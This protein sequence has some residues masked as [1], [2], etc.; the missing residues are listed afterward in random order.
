MGPVD[1]HWGANMGRLQRI[2]GAAL[3][4]Y[5]LVIACREAPPPA[6][7]S[8]A[9]PPPGLTRSE[10][11][12]LAAAEVALPPAGLN[13]ADLPAPESPG[14]KLVLQYCGQCHAVPSPSAHSATDWPGVVRRMW[15]RMEWLPDSFDIRTPPMG[16][17]FAMLQY[18]TANALKVSGA[19]LPPGP[20]RE[21]FT[22]TCSRCHDLPDPRVHSPQDWPT[23]V[24][25]MERNVERMKVPVDLG[26]RAS[27]ILLY[28]QQASLR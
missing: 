6:Q 5:G 8:S 14:A 27:D 3:L 13:P 23:V 25:R 11:L 17:R 15:L 9:A 19:T 18:L 2:W 12:L 22:L 26:A 28:L 20:G 24:Q 16:E 1:L 10:W 7:S 4:C 21:T